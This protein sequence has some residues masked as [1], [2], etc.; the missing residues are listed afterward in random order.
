MSGQKSAIYYQYV[1][2][3]SIIHRVIVNDWNVRAYEENYFDMSQPLWCI[4]KEERQFTSDCVRRF[5]DHCNDGRH[6]SHPDVQRDIAACFMSSV[7]KE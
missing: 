3:P 1:D 2:G 6:D 5:R 4:Y 7:R